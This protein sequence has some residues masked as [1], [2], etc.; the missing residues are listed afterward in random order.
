MNRP[1]SPELIG[2]TIRRVGIPTL[3]KGVMMRSRL[4]AR[5][6]AFF[7]A[8]RWSWEYE[9]DDLAGY[10]PDFVLGFEAGDVLVEVK[11]RDEDLALAQ[12]KIEVSGWER[13]AI[14]VVA[15]ATPE[16]GSL[17]AYDG[18]ELQWQAATLFRCLSCGQPSLRSVEGS[19][20]CRICGANAGNAHVG[21]FDPSE[22]WNEAGNRVQWRK[23]E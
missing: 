11:P 22:A 15:A 23:P 21:D 5:W 13:E 18:G 1:I 10:I 16:I 7:D 3:Y 4:E 8:L 2:S 20:R 19:W 14:V 9:P 6:A 12:S 17:M